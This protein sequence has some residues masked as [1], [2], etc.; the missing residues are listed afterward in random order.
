MSWGLGSA[1]EIALQTYITGHYT[2]DHSENDIAPDMLVSSSQTSSLKRAHSGN[3][4]NE[5]VA[6]NECWVGV[7][8]DLDCVFELQFLSIISSKEGNAIE[9][10][11]P[12]RRRWSN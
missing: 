11:C 12:S 8:G 6:E 7:V 5:E 4:C 9:S 3:Q 2:K 1:Q 10:T